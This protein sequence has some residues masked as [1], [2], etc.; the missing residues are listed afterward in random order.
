MDPQI[1]IT[2]RTKKIGILM[3]DARLAAGKSMK[4][5]GQAIGVSSSTIGSYERGRKSPSLPELELLANYLDIALEHFWQDEIISDDEPLLTED[6]H[7]E[8]ALAMRDR[9]IG[10]ILEEAR[11]KSEITYKEI[12]AKTSIS[13]GRMK[14]YEKGENPVPIPELELLTNLLGLTIHQFID[15]TTQVGKWLIAQSSIEEFLNLPT[16]L[17]LF[18]TKPVNQPYL[19]LARKLSQMSTEELRSV[20]EG[21]LEITI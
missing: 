19:E 5:C 8:H 13:A 17:Q 12:K 18:V 4:E 9:A 2:L 20:A 11:T 21:L 7:I 15:P 1:A 14:R 16:E 10:K 3:R 6:L